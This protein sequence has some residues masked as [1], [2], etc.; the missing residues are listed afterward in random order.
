MADQDEGE[1]QPEEGGDFGVY[2][3]RGNSDK[4]QEMS[5]GKVEDLRRAI[6]GVLQQQSEGSPLWASYA[7]HEILY[8]NVKVNIQI[9]F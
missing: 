6:G 5:I 9:I 2:E 4:R 8:G 3:D 7:K 1:N